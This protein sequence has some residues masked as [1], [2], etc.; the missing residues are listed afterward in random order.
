MLLF[1]YNS[2]NVRVPIISVVIQ[3]IVFIKYRYLCCEWHVYG[4]ENIFQTN[5]EV[6]QLLLILGVETFALF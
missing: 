4:L 5:K 6:H 2:N 3:V 1:E